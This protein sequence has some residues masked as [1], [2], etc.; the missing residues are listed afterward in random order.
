MC[1]YEYK[2]NDSWIM[3]DFAYSS[4][5]TVFPPDFL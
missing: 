4:S 5:S 3:D 1:A 2:I